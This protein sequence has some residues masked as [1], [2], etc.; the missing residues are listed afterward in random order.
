MR[1]P[2]PCSWRTACS[3]RIASLD[4]DSARTAPPRGGSLRK[5]AG[6]SRRE[7]ATGASSDLSARATTCADGLRFTSGGGSCAFAIAAAREA[8]LEPRRSSVRR[9][10]RVPHMPQNFMPG[11]F[12]WPHPAH[13]VL[14]AWCVL[15]ST[16]RLSMR[17]PQVPQNLYSGRFSVPQKVQSMR[18]LF[19]PLTAVDT[20]LLKTAAQ[21]FIG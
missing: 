11:S 3:W 8:S 14:P 13:F 10:I 18:A 1:P 21:L 15:R 20:R 19:T 12:T 2:F 5:M 4:K 17:T 9:S 16:C 7:S 6:S